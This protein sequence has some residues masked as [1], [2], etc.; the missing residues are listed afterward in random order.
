MPRMRA[1]AYAG[2]E[3]AQHIRATKF[4][5]AS[6]ASVYRAK[7]G[8]LSRSKP[9][10]HCR[11]LSPPLMPVKSYAGQGSPI[12]RRRALH[13]SERIG[14]SHPNETTPEP[15]RSGRSSTAGIE[16]RFN[17]GSPV[18]E[19]SMLP[20]PSTSAASMP[21]ALCAGRRCRTHATSQRW[22]SSPAC[23]FRNP[24]KSRRNAPQ[25]AEGWLGGLLPFYAPIQG[26][27]RTTTVSRRG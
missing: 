3:P 1:G 13:G 11:R 18:C 22:P 7:C 4:C 10:V 23:R 27:V 2:E 5:S 26:L 17:R 15:Q 16:L 19:R 21:G 20:A 14:S 9:K 12:P 24:R 8:G 25:N 6:C